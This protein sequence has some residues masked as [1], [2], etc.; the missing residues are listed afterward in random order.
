MLPNRPLFDGAPSPNLPGQ[1]RTELVQ[2]A[3]VIRRHQ[4]WS[5]LHLTDTPMEAPDL[6]NYFEEGDRASQKAWGT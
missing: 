3:F 4:P 6:A 2:P 1:I 5:R